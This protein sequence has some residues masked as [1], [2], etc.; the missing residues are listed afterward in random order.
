MTAIEAVTRKPLSSAGRA[1]GSMILCTT[2]DRDRPKLWPMRISPPGTLST[3]PTVAITVRKNTPNA[4][5]TIFEPS[6]M[7]TR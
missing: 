1:P 6:P 7:R 5:V 3:Q 4:N 2:A